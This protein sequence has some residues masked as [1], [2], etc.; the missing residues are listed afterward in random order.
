MTGDDAAAVP[1]RTVAF[2][3]VPRVLH[4]EAGA[5]E[6]THLFLHGDKEHGPLTVQCRTCNEPAVTTVRVT[7]AG[8]V[9]ACKACGAVVLPV[10]TGDD[11]YPF[12]GYHGKNW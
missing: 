2:G 3:M 9:H 8:P 7:A 4:T 11:P 10:V 6:V 1:Q 12:H 5:T